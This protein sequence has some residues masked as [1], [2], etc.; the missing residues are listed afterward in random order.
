MPQL[1]VEIR[2]LAARA[3]HRR[4]A[5]DH[6]VLGVAGQT[7][8]RLI[9]ALDPRVAIGHHD[10]FQCRFEHAVRHAQ[11]EAREAQR[12]VALAQ[13]AAQLVRVFVLDAQQH[14]GEAKQAGEPPFLVA[15]ADVPHVVLGHEALRRIQALRGEQ[16]LQRLARA[17][18]HRAS[19]AALS[20]QPHDVAF[21]EDAVLAVVV[22][23]QNRI[24]PLRAHP[25][26]DVGQR[27]VLGHH[28]GQM[29]ADRFDRLQMQEEF[30]A[31]VHDDVGLRQHADRRAV[32]DHDE[33]PYARLLESHRGFAQRRR[34]V[35]RQH[36]TA[37]HVAHRAVERVGIVAGRQRVVLGPDA[38]DLL[39][40]HHDDRAAALGEHAP[41]NLAHR[42]GRVAGQDLTRDEASNRN[43]VAVRVHSLINT[44]SPR[45]RTSIGHPAGSP[46][47]AGKM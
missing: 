16:H 37:H 25:R 9:H 47:T 7:R 43:I 44:K 11:V 14:V 35:E 29:D 33:V 17:C 32:A 4:V 28:H 34:R 36:R 2:R 30:R 1:L 23:D 20:Q 21:G 38:D 13:R 19:H 3:Q 22:T 10:P 40:L 24:E 42:R 6:F 26:D 46:A 12:L 27:I 39:A 15:D 18:A 45:R 5:A 8:E 31:L 41:R